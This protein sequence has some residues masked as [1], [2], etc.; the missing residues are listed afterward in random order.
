[1]KRDRRKPDSLEVFNK[2]ISSVRTSEKIDHLEGSRRYFENYCLCYKA[3]G[4]ERHVFE[5]EYDNSRN[6][7]F[8][9]ENEI[10]ETEKK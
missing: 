5:Y 6:R 10:I 8:R 3:S 1:M 9:N 2:V 7:I 4:Y